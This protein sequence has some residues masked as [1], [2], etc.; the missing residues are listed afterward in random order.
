MNVGKLTFGIGALHETEKNE[1]F[2]FL[3]ENF[4]IVDIDHDDI[5]YGNGQ[6]VTFT[7]KEKKQFQ[8]F[9][10]ANIDGGI[11]EYTIECDSNFN[12]NITLKQ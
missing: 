10:V 9:S 11:T 8:W 12:F 6:T 5:I 2:D 3:E 7:L 1:I 4:Y